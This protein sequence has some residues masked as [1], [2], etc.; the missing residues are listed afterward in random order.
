MGRAVKLAINLP[1]ELYA[2]AERERRA[3]HETRSEFFRHALAAFLR[4]RSK[5]KVEPSAPGDPA[6]GAK[7]RRRVVVRR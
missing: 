1:E 3:R 5:G 6:R 2:A 7:L 4:D